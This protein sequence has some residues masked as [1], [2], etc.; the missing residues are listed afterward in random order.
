[1]FFLLSEQ[2]SQ[3]HELLL[4]QNIGKTFYLFSHMHIVIIADR[5]WDTDPPW[6]K[7]QTML[8]LSPLSQKFSAKLSSSRFVLKLEYTKPYS[9]LFAENCEETLVKTLFLRDLKIKVH[10]FAGKS[11]SVWARGEESSRGSG[12][13]AQTRSLQRLSGSFIFISTQTYQYVLK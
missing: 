4:L 3:D 10:F 9:D 2:S 12:E 8:S 1:M 6:N 13:T 7:F 5:N 11:K